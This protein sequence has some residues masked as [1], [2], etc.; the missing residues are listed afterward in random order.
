[1]EGLLDS[2]GS[3]LTGLSTK[4]VDTLIAE[5]TIK[6]GMLPKIQCAL[7]AV[8]QGVTSAHI[9]DGRVPHAALLE[10]FSDDGIGTLISNK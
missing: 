9:I 3:V 2:Q 7:D 6:G 10:I 4:Q 5:G 1:M 8:K